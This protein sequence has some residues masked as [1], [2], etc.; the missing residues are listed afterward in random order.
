MRMDLEL[1]LKGSEF[2]SKEAED[3]AYARIIRIENFINKL[4]K[5]G[6]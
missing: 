5:D 6:K 2:Q 4:E 1:F 3:L